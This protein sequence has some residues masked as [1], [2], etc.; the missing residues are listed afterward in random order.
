M[1]RVMVKYRVKTDRAQEN[2]NLI[3]KVFEELHGN[4]LTELRYASFQLDDGVTFVHLAEMDTPDG[5]SPL[6]ATDAFK[7]FQADLKSRC[8]EM[9]VVTELHEVGTFN[10]F[11]D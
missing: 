10:I 5:S 9:P 3:R 7:A 6:T 11:S 2:A 1:K 4:P 8:E